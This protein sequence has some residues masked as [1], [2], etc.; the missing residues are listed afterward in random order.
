M[1]HLRFAL[2]VSFALLVLAPAARAQGTFDFLE[3]TYVGRWDNITFASFGDAK[4]RFDI[5]G[6]DVT[7]TVD[8][9]GFVFGLLDPDPV[10]FAG[11]I[12]GNEI[13]IDDTVMTYGMVNA[14]VG[15]NGAVSYTLTMVPMTGFVDITGTGTVS[16]SA[17][18]L[19]YDIDAGGM[20]M[21]NG[22]VTLPE[23]GEGA[24][25]GTALLALAVLRRR[26]RV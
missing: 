26:S 11:T 21:F 18:N 12:V 13:R 17:F 1:T 24:A 2:A 6:S 4:V 16:D 22:T 20:E 3:R 25:R 14:T 15:S 10:A 8:M 23:P 19:T 5:A 9:D 7:M